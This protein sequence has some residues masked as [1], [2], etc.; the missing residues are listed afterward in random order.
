MGQRQLI[1]Q[2][3]SV[4]SIRVLT[5]W[6]K[7]LLRYEQSMV[8]YDLFIAFQELHQNLIMALNQ[9]ENCEVLGYGLVL[10]CSTSIHGISTEQFKN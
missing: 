2:S 4:N 6:N 1:N 9:I 3:V 10:S 5:W 7:T 8:I